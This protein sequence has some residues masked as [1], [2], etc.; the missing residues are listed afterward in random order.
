[1]KY[2]Y[3]TEALYIDINTCKYNNEDY[4]FEVR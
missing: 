4:G 2:R 3:W 1:M